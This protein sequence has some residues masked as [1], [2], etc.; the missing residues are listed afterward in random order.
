MVRPVLIG[1]ESSGATRDALTALGIYARSADLLP[2]QTP[3]LH[4]QGDVFN[5]LGGDPLTGEPWGAALF[6][7]TCTMH[8][9]SAAWAFMDP[10]FDRYPGVGYHQRVKTGTLTGAARRAARDEQEQDL[11][12]IRLAD[13]PFK[14]VENPRGTIPKRLPSYGA[15]C[16]VLQ[17]YE[18]GDDASKATCIWAFNRAGR[19]IPVRFHRDPSDYVKPRMVCESCNGHSGYD[20]AF[21]Q[22]CPHCGAEAGRLKPRWANQT[23]SGQNRVSPSS[24][25]W[26]ERS[27]TYPGIAKALAA[28]LAA[29]V[30]G[31]ASQ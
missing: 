21:G 20:M 6:H 16:D 11:E 22:G 14:L 18:F 26:A 7:P 1:M 4:T 19:K 24:E 17:P 31:G 3:G 2:S 15:P 12:R 28:V 10:N 25:R 30:G 9:V 27:K 8:V 23:D 5:I 29:A 13:I